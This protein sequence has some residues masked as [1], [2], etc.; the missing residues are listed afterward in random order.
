MSAAAVAALTLAS[1][2]V[3]EWP[4]ETG[5]T[6][7]FV[8]YMDFDQDLPLHKEV[9]YTRDGGDDDSRASA[10][11]YDIRYIVNVYDVTDEN[12]ENRYVVDSYSFSQPYVDIHDFRVQL[13]LP[14]GKYKFRV[15][16]DHV[17]TTTL[18]DYFYVTSDYTE[19][20]LDE[21]EGHRG[22]NELRDAFRGTAYGEVYDPE[23]YSERNGVSPDNS[24]HAQMKRP[25]G[26]YEFLSTDM[27]EFLD[28]AI[29]NVDATRLAEVMAKAAASRGDG[30]TKGEIFWNGLTRDEVAE[31]IGLN[32]YKVVFSYNAFMPSS[33]NF[34]TD[35]PSD[36][37]TGVNY[38]SKM[39]IGNNG[40]QLGFDY[41]LVDDETT[42][43]VN[44][45]VQ[46]AD[47]DV[48]A[49]T[50]GVEVPVARSKNTVVKGAFL[51]V[52]SGGGV[53]INPD[54]DGPDFDIEIH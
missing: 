44:M 14:E 4:K 46:N 13:N 40:M 37:L 15:W 8:L 10:S 18:D 12:D 52:S 50:S 21:S 27:D 32:D 38:E 43:N 53:S 7:P 28:K 19:I 47:G 34:Y 35:K 33:Y 25:M 23:L 30:D 5:D 11:D 1:C 24:A 36:S 51:T 16:C 22:S 3:H 26:R 49:S 9:Y 29:Q 41:I 31:A 45:Q 17:K 54:F 6:Y 39:Q 2:N 20:K 48:I 42:M